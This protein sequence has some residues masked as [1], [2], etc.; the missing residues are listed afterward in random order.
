MATSFSTG[1]VSLSE[2]QGM[3]RGEKNGKAGERGEVF[4][5]AP[6][7]EWREKRERVRAEGDGDHGELCR[8]AAGGG[9]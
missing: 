6:E 3:T 9:G 7:G 2:L 8:G 1:K 5:S 4:E